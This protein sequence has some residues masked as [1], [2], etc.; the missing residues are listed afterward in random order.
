MAALQSA[1]SK[2]HA[3]DHQYKTRQTKICAGYNYSSSSI[4]SDN[5]KMG[6]AFAWNS[7]G[8]EEYKI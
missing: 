7:E 4:N 6:S 1:Y 5:L 3:Y 2:M 8:I